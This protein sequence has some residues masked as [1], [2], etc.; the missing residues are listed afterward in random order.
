MSSEFAATAAWARSRL[1]AAT[2]PAANAN[3][4]RR[5]F[6]GLTA[7]TSLLYGSRRRA[8]PAAGEGPAKLGAPIQTYLM[9]EQS[10]TPK[11]SGPDRRSKY[12]DLQRRRVAK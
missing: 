12:D 8:A 1:P 10:L 6:N 11:I 3:R 5:R 9:Y 2:P 4:R 7:M